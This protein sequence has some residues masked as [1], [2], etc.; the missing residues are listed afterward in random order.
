MLLKKI[1]IFVIVS[2]ATTVVLICTKLAHETSIKAKVSVWCVCVCVYI[3][4]L[5]CLC[6]DTNNIRNKFSMWIS[7]IEKFNHPCGLMKDL[8]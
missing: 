3:C 2:M 5:L 7:F 4:L 8:R 1:R 6:V